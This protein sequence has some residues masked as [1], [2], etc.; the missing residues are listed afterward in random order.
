L[1]TRMVSL[2]CLKVYHGAVDQS[3]RWRR[4]GAFRRNHCAIG[5]KLSGG[6]CTWISKA[7]SRSHLHSACK[8]DNQS[9]ITD[10][11]LKAHCPLRHSVCSLWIRLH[12]TQLSIRHSAIQ[13]VLCQT[14]VP[15]VCVNPARRWYTRLVLQYHTR[16]VRL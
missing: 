6:D 12:H 4:Y 14:M 15:T 13:R 3:H 16:L 10:A 5:D 11:T 2:C 9:F 7:K 8:V 1:H